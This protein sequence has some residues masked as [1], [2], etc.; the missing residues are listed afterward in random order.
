MDLLKEDRIIQECIRLSCQQVSKD[1]AKIF[2]NLMMQGRLTL[3]LKM[4]T[5]DPPQWSC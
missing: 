2:A 4:L 3:A 1:Y 5:S